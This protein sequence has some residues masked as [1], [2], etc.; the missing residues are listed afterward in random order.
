MRIYLQNTDGNHIYNKA[1]RILWG[2]M[3]WE[4]KIYD[5]YVH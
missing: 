3:K 5:E 2:E 4:K 1:L